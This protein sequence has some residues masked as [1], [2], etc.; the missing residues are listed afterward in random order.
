MNHE[1]GELTIKHGDQ[2]REIYG[3]LTNQFAKSRILLAFSHS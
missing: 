2:H 3:D 1:N